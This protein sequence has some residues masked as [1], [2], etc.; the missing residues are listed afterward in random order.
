MIN[1]PS[2]FLTSFPLS[3]RPMKSYPFAFEKSLTI[4]LLGFLSASSPFLSYFTPSAFF[5]HFLPTFFSQNNGIC[6][7]FKSFCYIQ[8]HGNGYGKQRQGFKE[9]QELKGS[10]FLGLNR[11][12]NE[13]RIAV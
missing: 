7:F 11:N 12:T 3:C 8:C 9:S 2:L 13:L 5:F 4:L 6:S 1:S 10:V